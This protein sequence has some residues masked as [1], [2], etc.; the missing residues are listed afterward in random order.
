MKTVIYFTQDEVLELLEGK[1]V[2]WVGRNG[3]SY[4]AKMIKEKE[5]KEKIYDAEST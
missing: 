4:E 1:T 5:E 2:A 3:G